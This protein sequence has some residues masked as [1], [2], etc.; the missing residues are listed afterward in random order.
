MCHD[1][2]ITEGKSKDS[3]GKEKTDQDSFYM[4]YEGKNDVA[5]INCLIKL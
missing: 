2:V 4:G 5:S 1:C 3:R